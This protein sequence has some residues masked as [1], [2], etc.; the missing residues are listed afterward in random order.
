MEVHLVFMLSDPKFAQKW[1]LNPNF[2]H[3]CFSKIC[4]L[5]FRPNKP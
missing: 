4:C 5:L 1:R 3:Q 2:S